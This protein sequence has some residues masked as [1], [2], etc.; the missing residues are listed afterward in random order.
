MFSGGNLSHRV[1]FR[2]RSRAPTLQH[3]DDLSVFVNE[4]R[5]R[6]RGSPSVSSQ[7]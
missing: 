3:T 4:R 5:E 2:R 1:V 6:S 7:C